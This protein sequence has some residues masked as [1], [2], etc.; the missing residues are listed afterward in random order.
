MPTI[1]FPFFEVLNTLADDALDSEDFAP[2]RNVS[3]TVN[4]HQTETIYINIIDDIKFEQDEDFYVEITGADVG[5]GISV[6]NVTIAD[7][8]RK[9]FCLVL[10]FKLLAII[11]V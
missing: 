4:S 8:D 11:T 9:F 10:F 5:D 3:A 6:V 1:V 2:V 7:D